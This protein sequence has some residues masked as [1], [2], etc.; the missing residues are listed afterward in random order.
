[1]L[2]ELTKREL[3]NE[4]AMGSVSP[5][6]FRSRVLPDEDSVIQFVETIL[7][8]ALKDR[9]ALDVQFGLALIQL[10]N[11]S[12]NKLETSLLHILL[13][14]DWHFS[15]EDLA[16]LLSQLWNPQSVNCLYDAAKLN[17]PYLSYD[18]T[19]QLARKCIKGLGAIGDL[20]ASRKLQDLA[21]DPRKIV[22]QYAEQ[23]LSLI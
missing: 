12:W 1:M 2:D 22:G 4:L 23:E 3:L 17:L 8:S 5:E 20:H 6:V 15:H 14:E 13:L 16:F 21:S 19:F 18:E 10:D 9:D 7:T 11:L